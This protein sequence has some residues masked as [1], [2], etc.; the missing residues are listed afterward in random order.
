ML[1]PGQIIEVARTIA[2]V[3]G[4]DSVLAARVVDKLVE[5]WEEEALFRAKLRIKALATEIL[6]ATQ[7]DARPLSARIARSINGRREG[8]EA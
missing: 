5:K 2:E 1:N 3:A 4:H 8:E 7:Q 6:V